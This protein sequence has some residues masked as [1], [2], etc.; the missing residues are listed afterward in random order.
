MRLIASLLLL[1]V[2]AP[3]L[4]ADPPYYGPMKP[5]HGIAIAYKY[6]YR[7]RPEADGTWRVEATVRFG[8][9]IDM[10]M[11]RAAELA[12]DQGYAY[13]QFLGGQVND[14][15][16][17]HA[18][19]VWTRFSH[20][21]SPATGCRSKERG[22]CY[23]ADVAEVLRVLGGPGGVQPGVAIVD[24]RDEHGLN[25]FVSGFGI[26]DVTAMPARTAPP[27]TTAIA[28]MMAPASPATVLRART[29]P[30]RM[31]DAERY[32]AL[33]AAQPR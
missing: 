23:T 16:G 26:G 5:W 11:Y 22:T 27:I 4:A 29:G 2:A 3:A 1:A 14:I 31:S 28:S 13:V 9:A 32:R 18:A 12:R 24:H 21:A 8:W 25:V 7:E 33:L 15:L 6:G 10:A 19:T 30:A 17:N 20:E